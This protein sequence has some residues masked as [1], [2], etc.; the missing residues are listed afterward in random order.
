MTPAVSRAPKRPR[1]PGLGPSQRIVVQVILV[2]AAVVVGC[3]SIRSLFV[4]PAGPVFP[5]APHAEEGLECSTCHPDAA[6]GVT[7][8]FPPSEKGCLLCHRDKDK[9]KPQER[10]VAAF[11]VDGKARWLA[12]PSAYA[13]ATGDAASRPSGAASRP[14]D[15]RFD[16]GKHAAAGVA[17]ETCHAATIDGSG[18]GLRIEGGKATCLG[19]H[20][21]KS[22]RGDE[23]SVCHATL[24]KDVAPPSHAASWRLVHGADSRRL[25][26]GLGETTCSQC[27][28]ESSCRTCHQEEA[29]ANH[30]NFWRRQGHGLTA[31]I[32]RGKC[33]TCHQEDYCVR[34]HQQATPTSHRSGFGPPRNRHCLSC[35]LPPT[36]GLTCAT[37]HQNLGTHQQGPAMPATQVHRTARSPTDCRG[38][39]VALSHPDPGT[40]CRACHR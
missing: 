15:V 30:T 25:I 12:R 8:G 29:P 34:C 32:D 38:C 5:H 27:H 21:Q 17:C 24:R 1:P 19:C 18:T 20:R 39:H 40:D 7:A 14:S 36:P 11:L 28:Q 13:P 33:A 4:A 16:H 26:E 35:H 9:D 31:A 6:S 10:T 23:C 2:A 37:C 3:Q 22:T